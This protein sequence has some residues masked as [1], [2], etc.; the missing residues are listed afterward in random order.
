M[1][2]I[3]PLVFGARSGAHLTTATNQKPLLDAYLTNLSTALAPFSCLRP[4]E[5]MH[6]N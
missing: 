6:P 3:G 1:L 2:G 4:T 5:Y